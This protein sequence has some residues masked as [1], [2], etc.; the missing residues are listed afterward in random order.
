M[1]TVNPLDY[2]EITTK[3]RRRSSSRRRRSP[4]ESDSHSE[5][6]DSS[7]SNDDEHRRRR[8]SSSRHR[9]LPQA[10]HYPYPH[11]SYAPHHHAGPQAYAP[12]PDPRAQ[13]IIT[14]AMQQLSALVGAPWP[15]PPPHYMDGSVPHT[16]SHRSQSR[17][18]SVIPSF[19]P[20]HHE[21]PYPYGYDPNLSR[22]TLPPDSPE[23]ASSPEKYSSGRRKSLVRRSRSRGRRVSFKFEG[24]ERLDTPDRS[25]SPLNSSPLKDRP[26]KPPNEKEGSRL[27]KGKGKAKEEPEYGDESQEDDTPSRRG[28]SY[29]RGQTPGPSSD[30]L[31]KKDRR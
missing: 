2:D 18:P 5:S 15:I 23:V 30:S 28:R 31:P 3:P 25:S 20:T 1:L 11:S 13:F 7:A 16:P 8:R 19:T 9:T 17:R 27:L 10:A 6:G 29:S 26:K 12:I 24:E 21:H 14:Q 4:S 22:A